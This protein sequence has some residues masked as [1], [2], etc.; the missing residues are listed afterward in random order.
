[1]GDERYGSL[2][3]DGEYRYP[4]Q[5]RRPV[6]HR[7]LPRSRPSE[8]P[9]HRDRFEDA[10][11]DVQVQ[12]WYG[13][14]RRDARGHKIATFT[15]GA[16][17]RAFDFA[18]KSEL[19]DDGL[20]RYHYDQK[21]RLDW[22]ADKA[23]AT[24]VLIRRIFYTYDGNNR[25]VGRTAQ[26]ATVTSLTA[27][28]DTFTWNLEVRPEM[29]AADGIPAETMFVWDPVSDRIIAVMRTGESKVANNNTLK[30]II[31]GDMS[32]D[33]PLEVTTLDTSVI[34]G[35]GET[36]PVTKLYPIYDEAAGGTLQV[37]LN[38]NGELVA[39]S[40]N[41]D[42]FGGA[43][44]DLAGAAID[45]VAVQATK[46]AQGT[47][48]NVAVTMRATEQLAAASIATG[49]R[50]AVVDANGTVV[51]TSTAQPTLADACTG[52]YWY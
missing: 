16:T 23:T 13:S 2:R 46:N 41:N 12:R 48:D 31:H 45:H 9:H 52:Y 1:M 3:R 6:A 32:Y 51:R 38:K 25:L 50:L 10:G 34:V 44:F 19:V 37:V 35:P 29:I 20:K 28:Y 17:T 39:R 40:I 49:T 7:R 43:E 18:G 11:A 22:A 24:G 42:A 26:A 47:L 5:R 4:H 21:G 8:Q 33:D 36:Q 14:A 15:R 30:Q 27:S